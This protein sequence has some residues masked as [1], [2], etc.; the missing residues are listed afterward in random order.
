MRGNALVVW[1]VGLLIASSA[2]ASASELAAAEAK[3]TLSF[4]KQY[5]PSAWTQEMGYQNRAKG[6]F[7]FGAK[8]ALLSCTEL[9]NEPREMAESNGNVF[10][11][12]GHGLRNMLGDTVGGAIHLVTFPITT[13][14][15]TLPEGGTDLL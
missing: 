7:L 15:V 4:T 5:V 3:Y 1:T 8:N 12:I 6:K 14:D 2:V 9:Y 11:G 13:V 10:V